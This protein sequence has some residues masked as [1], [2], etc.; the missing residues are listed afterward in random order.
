MPAPQAAA[1][2][3][4]RRPEATLLSEDMTVSDLLDGLAV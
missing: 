3:P 4:H 2:Q 1:V